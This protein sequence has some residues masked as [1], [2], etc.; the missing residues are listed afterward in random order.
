MRPRRA[1]TQP[2]IAD[3]RNPSARFAATHGTGAPPGRRRRLPSVPF[4]WLCGSS[5]WASIW[6]SKAL[7]PLLITA[8]MAT[9][10]RLLINGIRLGWPD[11]DQQP[12]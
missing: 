8:A 2:L 1:I 12:W 4:R 9:A 7:S 11:E 3:R 5:L 6:S 10:W